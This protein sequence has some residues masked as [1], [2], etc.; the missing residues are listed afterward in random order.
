M[1]VAVSERPDVW[2]RGNLRPAVVVALAA[3][4]CAGLLPA[5]GIL[6]AW[7]FWALGLAGAGAGAL[8]ALA[9]GLVWAAAQPRLGRQGE[10]MLVRLAPLACRR[11]P[12]EIV[13]CVFRGTE[14]VAAAGQPPRYRVGTI[15]LRLAER[16]KEWRE[17]ETF[18]PWG[19]WED[20][21]IVIDGRWCEPLSPE[22]AQQIAARLA[23]AKRELAAGRQP[24]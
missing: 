21:Y 22:L 12:L 15:A 14:P 11:V 23:D 7:P 13:E 10:F 4:V 6:A 16:A 8:L 17:R 24:R 2:L 20:G 9:A 18:R 1:M 5:A 19:T 3:V